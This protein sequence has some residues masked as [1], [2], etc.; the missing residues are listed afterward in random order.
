MTQMTS[1]QA[2][3]ALKML[4]IRELIHAHIHSAPMLLDD[5]LQ[6][7]ARRT[8]Q[9]LD[10][11]PA[12]LQE[13]KNGSDR[14]RLWELSHSAACPVTGVCLQFHEVQK[15]ALKAGLSI[16]ASCDYDLHGMVLQEC[17]SRSPLAKLLQQELDR[18]FAAQI[19]RSQRLK[20]VEAL[21]QWWNEAC[22][23]GTWAGAFW[24]VLTH[25]RC[26]SELEHDLLGQVY[27]LQHQADL[28]ARADTTQ[29][30]ALQA[31]NKRL[32]QELKDAQ[33]RLQFQAT[34][35]AAVLV[36][37]RSECASLRTRVTRAETERDLAQTESVVINRTDP[38]GRSHQRLQQANQRRTDQNEKLLM[39][40]LRREAEANDRHPAKSSLGQT[41]TEGDRDKAPDATATVVDLTD[42]S[43]LCVGGRTQGI[44]VYRKVIESRGAH[45][46]HHDGG[47]ENNSS[48][49]GNQLQA[50]DLVICQVA[51]ISHDAYWRV[52]EH[53]KRTGKVC[54]FVEM[55]SR[56]ALERA[57]TQ[58]ASREG[59]A[60][61]TPT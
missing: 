53:C 49:L 32:T 38:D 36:A 13:P 4:R 19:Q 17:K 15:I 22:Q 9:A 45:F 14:R 18:R 2:Y 39:R 42:R 21:T 51:C 55:P 23:S 43:V 61:V 33:Q 16:A 12:T 30:K 58:L 25:P 20:T 50:A 52:K 10:T 57:L 54:L 35:H 59:S 40:A 46:M 8:T 6:P 27:M 34:E 60:V 44:P 47:V 11:P 5:L 26:S 28:A 24:T 41:D 31:E 29:F 56:S 7:Y 37:I 3:Q 1:N 48:R